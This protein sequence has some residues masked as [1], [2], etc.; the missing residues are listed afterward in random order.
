MVRV[1]DSADQVD[2]DRIATL[3][4]GN[5][6]VA[7][8]NLQSTFAYINRKLGLSDMAEKNIFNRHRNESGDIENYHE[9]AD[10]LTHAIA[11]AETR[12]DRSDIM[13]YTEA[14][15]DLLEDRSTIS[16][17]EGFVEHLEDEGYYTVALSSAPKAVSMPFAEE[18]GIE[19]V[20]RFRDFVFDDEGDFQMV[21]VDPDAPNGKKDVVES[22]QDEADEVL[23]VGNG[24]NDL[25]A[26]DQ[27]DYSLQRHDWVRNPQ[28]YEEAKKEI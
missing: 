17:A 6:L 16:E 23:H 1:V 3:D 11:G 20:Y 4:M 9:H 28:V 27:A 25:G 5:T 13:I 8:E 14:V 12:S 19:A 21:Y 18:L 24:R 7:G 2:A 10:T 26:R 22:F 15:Q